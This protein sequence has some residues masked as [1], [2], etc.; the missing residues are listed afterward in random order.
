[1]R[2][3]HVGLT[4][5]DLDSAVNFFSELF[6]LEVTQ[7]RHLTGSYLAEMLDLANGTAAEVAF[8]RLN[9]TYSLELVQYS[10]PADAFEGLPPESLNG[11]INSPNTPH[12]AFFVSNLEEF[13]GR[14]STW[15]L[16]HLSEG[17][18][19][20]PAGPYEGSRISFFRSDFGCFLEIIEQHDA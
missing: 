8:L 4:V 17:I 18:Q 20:I 3:F 5:T 1:M 11:S 16:H 7:R 12:F 15:N 10:V 14:A 19:V 9:E 6:G 13:I 2:P